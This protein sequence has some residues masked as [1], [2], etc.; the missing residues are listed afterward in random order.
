MSKA[1]TLAAPSTMTTA[2]ML[3]EYNELTG[4]NTARFASRKAGEAALERARAAGP[5]VEFTMDE[6]KR[7]EQ[8]GSHAVPPAM[9]AQETEAADEAAREQGATAGCDNYLCHHCGTAFRPSGK[10][11]KPAKASADRAA[12]IGSSWARQD[13]RDARRERTSV[14]VLKPGEKDELVF[15]SVAEAFKKLGL[16]MGKHIKFR[17]QLK[18]AGKL[19]FGD[20]K[21]SATTRKPTN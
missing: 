13:V 11:I 20:L 5:K 9:T 16:P 15:K 21:F 18:A 7:E 10:I 8:M 12:S 4:K 14:A 1:S 19:A 6:A 3:A 2:A 17:A